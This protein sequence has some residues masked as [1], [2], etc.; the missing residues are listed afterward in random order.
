MLT[1]SAAWGKVYAC[2]GQGEHRRVESA[3]TFSAAAAE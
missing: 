1:L 3:V 2:Q